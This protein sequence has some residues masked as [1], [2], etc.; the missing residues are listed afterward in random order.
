MIFSI[1]CRAYWYH[2]EEDSRNVIVIRERLPIL[3]S[4]FLPSHLAILNNN[5][6]LHRLLH[7]IVLHTIIKQV[8]S[9]NRLAIH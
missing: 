8:F 5:L 3:S 6:C 4:G 9:C 1:V 2:K 7:R